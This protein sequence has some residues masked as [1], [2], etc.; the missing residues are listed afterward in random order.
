MFHLSKKALEKGINLVKMTLATC[1][2][3][4]L[5]VDRNDAKLIRLCTKC[6][7]TRQQSCIGRLVLA[8]SMGLVLISICK[9]QLNC[10]EWD[11]ILL[12][13]HGEDIIYKRPMECSYFM[14][15]RLRRVSRKD[16]L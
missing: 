6:I 5:A 4:T 8:T 10:A 16:C 14:G 7:D 2:F 1:Y 15:E 12:Q 9:R 3:H 13:I 11:R